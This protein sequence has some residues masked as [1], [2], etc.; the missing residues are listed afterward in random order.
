MREDVAL[1]VIHIDER[2]IEGE[3]ESFGE[4]STDEE[5]A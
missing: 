3:S 2:D 1:E 5:R 4:G